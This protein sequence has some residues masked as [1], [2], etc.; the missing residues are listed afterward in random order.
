MSAFGWILFVLVA[1]VAVYFL[2]RW[3][4]SDKNHRATQHRLMLAREQASTA[5]KD[6]EN[7]CRYLDSIAQIESQAI[8]L[9]DDSRIVVWLNESAASFGMSAVKAPVPLNRT[10]QNY[11]V[12]ELVDWAMADDLA[13]ERQ[14][15]GNG[16]VFHA[17][18]V[19]V[20]LEPALVALAVD[21]V[22]EL[23]RLG[24]ARRD[25]VA[26]IS[27]DLR[28]PIAAIQVMAE[29]LL[30]TASISAKRQKNLLR[31]ILDQ[32]ATLQQ[33]AQELLD[34]SMIES[35]RMPL[36]LVET[37]IDG[38][39]DPVVR[40]MS[41]QADRKGIVVRVDFDQDLSVLADADSVQRVLQNLLH[42]AIKFSETEGVITIRAQ[43]DGEDARFAVEDNG[44]GM[45]Q[46]DV[47]RIFERF[48]KADR[49]RSG[50]GTGLGLAIARHIIEGHGGRIWVESELGKGATFYFTLLRGG[51]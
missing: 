41:N 23:Q 2:W 22:T 19:R 28:T 25:F 51:A 47:N 14:F 6:T 34:L 44:L 15:G 46:E 29:T 35:G 45:A 30:G 36:R 42:N 5:A 18:A 50:S 43:A 1:L 21:D 11:E 20:H 39:I 13:H 48:F 37:P 24:R 12:L 32:S 17:Q 7:F 10:I 9:I 27:H 40:R 3:R 38:L 33:L 49:M 16:N 31:S 8:Y 4:T 26:N